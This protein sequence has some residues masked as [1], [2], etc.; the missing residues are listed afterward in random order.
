MSD[1]E[2]SGLRAPF[3]PKGDLPEWRLLYDA[4]LEQAE[5]GQVISYDQLDAALGRRFTD[6]RS[7]LYRARR[8][9]GELRRRWLDAVP[10]TGY[11]VIE[12]HEHIGLAQ[13]HKRRAKRQLGAMVR[14]AEVTDL[15]RLTPD[16]LASYDHQSRLNAMLYMVAVHHE[17]RLNRI[18]AVLR[19]EGML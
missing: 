3:A 6:N 19:K 1:V 18:E 9:M 16:Q 14:V 17:Q 7:P 11:R 15:D 8:E 5:F 10:G 2:R 13:R 4:L 12:A